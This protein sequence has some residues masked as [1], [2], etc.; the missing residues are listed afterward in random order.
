MNIMQY[1]WTRRYLRT[2]TQVSNKTT[3]T[4]RISDDMKY[5]DCNAQVCLPLVF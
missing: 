1:A 5:L 4:L 2:D 3:C